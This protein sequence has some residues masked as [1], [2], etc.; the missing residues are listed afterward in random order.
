MS[1]SA[2]VSEWQLVVVAERATVALDIF[3]DVLVRLPNDRGHRAR[4]IL[5]TSGALVGGHVAGIAAS[6]VRL[7]GGKLLYGNDEVVRR[8]VDATEGR[9]DRLRWISA[10]DGYAVVTCLEELLSM[11]GVTVPGRGA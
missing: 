2:S 1:F 7:I 3:R 8:F 6:G 9:A 11:A 10:D 4:E 5:R